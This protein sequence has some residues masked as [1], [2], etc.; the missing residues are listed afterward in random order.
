[1]H[2]LRHHLVARLCALALCTTA[3]QLYTAC[4]DPCMDL[5]NAICDCETTARAQQTCKQRVTNVANQRTASQAEQDRCNTLLGSC[6]C[7]ELSAGHL[8]ACG[9]TP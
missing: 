7:D 6:T 3:L 1:M 8:A 5:A 4:S 2:H 9:L